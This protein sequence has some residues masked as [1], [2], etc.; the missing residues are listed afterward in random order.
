MINLNRAFLPSAENINK[1]W[2]LIDAAGKTVG[3]MATD[4]AIALMG[5]NTPLYTPHVKTGCAIVV[6]NAEKVIFTGSKME[7]KVYR[8]YTGFIGNCKHFTAR[9]MLTRHP[10]H[11]IEAAVKRMLPKN[12]LGDQLFKQYFRVYAGSS[13]PHQG[14]VAA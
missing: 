10:E 13:H 2:F 9:E 8:K 3:R 7:D 14:Q 1:R 4:I 11:I 6:I 5:K 12:K